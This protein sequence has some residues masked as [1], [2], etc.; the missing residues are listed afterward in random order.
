MRKLLSILLIAAVLLSTGC[1]TKQETTKE[2]KEDT[3]R[4]AINSRLVS[5]DKLLIGEKEVLNLDYKKLIQIWGKPEKVQKVEIKFPATVE[6]NE[7]Y[8]L[9]FKGIDVEMYPCAK[10]VSVEETS[11]FRF[12]ITG[13][14]YE[15]F[16]KKIG[17]KLEDY[18][19]TVDNKLTYPIDE[20][21]KDTESKEIPFEYKKLLSSVKP[22]GWYKAY[23]G[24]S[25]VYEQVII[26]DSP[27]GAVMIFKN[28]RL[29]RMVYGYP[30]AS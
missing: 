11:S 22:L 21:L 6:S 12:D 25:A 1:T 30:N 5:A 17:M 8:I 23:S 15:F 27:Y 26:K 7:M 20:I 9:S 24:C 10:N 2:P 29:V 4:N 16:G 19:K 3:T 14:E 28:D 18:L 13:S